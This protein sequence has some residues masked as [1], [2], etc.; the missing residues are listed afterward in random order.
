MTLRLAARKDGNQTQ[1]AE[2]LRALGFDVDIVHREK[3]LYDLVVSGRKRIGVRNCRWEITCAVR[4]EV[5]MPGGKLTPDEDEYWNK[6]NHRGNLI[7][8]ETTD[9]VLRWF[10]WVI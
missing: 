2:E 4:V 6:Q 3:K 10:G 5:K 1:I 7:I 9:D 8:A